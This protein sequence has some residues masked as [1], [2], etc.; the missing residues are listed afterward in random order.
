MS[1]RGDTSPLAALLGLEERA[2]LAA[3]IT[4]L[5]F[6]MVNETRSLA[7]YR[8]A[9]LYVEGE[10]IVAVSGVSSVE[11]TAP[12][13]LWLERAFRRLG[14]KSDHGPA[15]DG[16][17]IAGAEILDEPDRGQW[18]EWLPRHALW[19]PLTDPDGASLGML[20]LARE[21]SWR[22]AEVVLLSRV[23]GCYG[24]SWAWR[25]RPGFLTRW[26]RIPLWRWIAVA[27]AM[28]SLF[29]PVRLSVLAP[30]EVVARDPAVI[31]APLEGVL[32]RIL[33]QPNEA[34]GKGQV[35]FELDRTR[36][37]GE[38]KIAQKALA[39]A[40]AEHEQT[41]QQ[42]F[43]DPR[44]KSG[45][46][47][48]RS[49]IDERRAEVAQ[50]RD[51]L[52]RS[53]ARAP[54]DGIAILDAH[55]EWTGR[56]VTV[57]EKVI[58]VADPDDTEVEAWLAPA[59]VI[60]LPRGNPVVVFLNTDPLHPIR[61]TLRYVAYQPTL[62]PDGQLAHRVRAAIE[63]GAPRPRLGLKGTARL[64]GR[65]VPLAFWLLR[66]PLAAVRQTLGI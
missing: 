33:V 62:R 8:Q 29:F 55:S 19:V 49:R 66:K 61:A 21:E 60:E 57:G 6:I 37:N 9:A 34:V 40:L 48:I 44:A 7:P 39:T 1:A 36:L 2:R 12:F 35:L 10:G 28:A 51:L 23:V 26:R 25:H 56:P 50:L 24:L 43:S 17:Q 4:E 64:D 20:M 41:T 27:L 13:T 42:S 31:R 15:G 3:S 14:Q 32:D 30:A 45:L 59:D 54:R 22:E 46:T 38:L 53:V 58:S 47:V 65:R 5:A 16:H 52:E 18:K 63:L 11:R